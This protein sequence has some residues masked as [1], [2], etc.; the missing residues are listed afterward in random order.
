MNTG[1]P[2]GLIC[3]AIIDDLLQ[4]QRALLTQRL[5]VLAHSH[6]LVDLLRITAWQG[7]NSMGGLEIALALTHLSG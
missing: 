6:Q 4:L 2:G 5:P 1:T 3:P 7:N